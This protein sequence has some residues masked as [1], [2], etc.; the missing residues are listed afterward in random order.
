MGG[1]AGSKVIKVEKLALSPSG[2]NAR[3]NPPSP[4]PAAA[5]LSTLLRQH[6]RADPVGGDSV[7][8]DL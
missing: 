6:T 4:L 7:E 2:S 5:G 3:D 8:L 1:R